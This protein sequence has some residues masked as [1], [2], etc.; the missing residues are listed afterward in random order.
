MTSLVIGD[1]Y[2]NRLR[3]FIGP[4][5]SAADV[6]N[7]QELST[8][9]YFG[10]SG[11][12]VNNNEHF[13]KFSAIVRQNQPRQLIVILGGNDLDSPDSVECVLNKLIAFLTQLKVLF[14]IKSVT[15]L[16]FFRRERTRHLSPDSYI[17]KVNIANDFLRSNCQTHGL[18]FWK[19]RG[20]TNSLAPLFIDGVHLNNRG[21]YKLLRQL[22]GLFLCLL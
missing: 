10:I 2:V 4:N 5:R 13:R 20:F 9:E 7:I 6:F 3:Q 11:G 16:S 15:I 22:R 8:V 17:Q 19:L 1:S 12:V 21:H 14:H 18:L